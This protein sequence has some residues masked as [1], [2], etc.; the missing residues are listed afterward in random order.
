MPG[1]VVPDYSR[2]AIQAARR[3]VAV[4]AE[5]ADLPVGSGVHDGMAFVGT[6]EGKSGGG[7]DIAA[8]GDSVNTAARLASAA[9]RER[10]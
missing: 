1:M 9:K 2:K 6:V 8:V 4:V 3:L 5:R 10:C 7:Q